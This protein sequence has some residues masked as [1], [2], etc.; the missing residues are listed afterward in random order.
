MLRALRERVGEWFG[1]D[2]EADWYRGSI[3]DRSVNYSHGG[4][5][6]DAE[7]ELQR[8]TEEAAKLSEAQREH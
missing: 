6:E 7:R 4:G 8:T 3:L 2:E 5:N 1:R